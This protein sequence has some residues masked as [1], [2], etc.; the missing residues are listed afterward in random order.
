MCPFGDSRT[1]ELWG[2]RLASLPAP[3]L[4]VMDPSWPPS[5]ITPSRQEGEQQAVD[6]GIPS[7]EFRWHAIPAHLRGWLRRL[8][9]PG[10]QEQGRRMDWFH[11]WSGEI[12]KGGIVMAVGRIMVIAEVATTG[13]ERNGKSPP[14][15]QNQEG[16]TQPP[17]FPAIAKIHVDVRS[18]VLEKRPSA[19]SNAAGGREK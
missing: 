8:R 10:G 17:R 5:G 6:A 14:Q 9:Q 12:L 3:P 13:R 19:L 7:A 4:L 2:C 15:I 16:R 11:A 18:V 1:G